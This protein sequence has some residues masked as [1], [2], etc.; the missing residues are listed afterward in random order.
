MIGEREGEGRDSLFDTFSIERDSSYMSDTGLLYDFFPLEG[1]ILELK[2]FLIGELMLGLF[3]EF[4][5]LWRVECA[6]IVYPWLMFP[7]TPYLW[8]ENFG[9]EF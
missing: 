8:R 2:E 1:P 3:V 7:L 5:S 6:D 4:K 9:H